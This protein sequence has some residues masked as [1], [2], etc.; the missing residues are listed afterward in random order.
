MGRGTS[1]WYWALRTAS[2]KT[3]PSPI[4]TN[5]SVFRGT[6]AEGF[7]VGF[8]VCFTGGF[9]E[10]SDGRHQWPIANKIPAGIIEKHYNANSAEQR[11]ATPYSTTRRT[12]LPHRSAEHSTSQRGPLHHSTTQ[13][14]RDTIV[15][16]T[17]WSVQGGIYI[18]IY[19]D[20]I[21][22]DLVMFLAMLWRS[23]SDVS[24]RCVGTVTHVGQT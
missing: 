7:T 4:S 3:P 12:A 8:T 21:L 9:T 10:G 24:W 5:E 16:E 20:I 1:P 22:Y 19:I 13:E 6:F 14:Q 23:I 2:R 17:R 18:Y 11:N 15:N